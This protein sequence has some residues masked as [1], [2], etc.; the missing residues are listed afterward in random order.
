MFHTL[1]T[2]TR[3]ISRYETAALVEER[4][5]YL[6]HCEASGARRSTLRAVAADQLNLVRLLDMQPGDRVGI[7][8]VEA[9]AEEWSCTKG[10]GRTAR[11]AAE[12]QR[13]FL[14][15]AV[16]WLRFLGNLEQ[17]KTAR[18]PD[19]DR[20]VA[21]SA[22]MR[23]ERGLSEATI[24]VYCRAAKGDLTACRYVAALSSS[25]R[26]DAPGRVITG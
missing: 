8:Q 7:A 13:R 16:R 19:A 12:R 14:G 10:Q 26:F 9:A 21:F 4:L 11:T 1:F 17:P 5:R 23:D 2:R 18:H 20:V 15:H 3:V 25:A 24:D 6:V 22:W